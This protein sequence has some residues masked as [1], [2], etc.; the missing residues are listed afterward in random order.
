M[1]YVIENEIIKL[2][3][4]SFGA[5]M[6]SIIKDGVEYLWQGD[7]TYWG[8]RAINLFPYCGRHFQGK[9]TYNGKEYEMKIHGLVKYHECNLVFKDNN[10]LVFSFKDNEETLKFYPFKFELLITYEIEND[11][12]KITYQVINNDEKKMYFAL[13][14]HPGFNIPLNDSLS[15][16]DYYIEFENKCNPKKI[17]YSDNGLIVDGYDDNLLE[18]NQRLELKHNLFDRDIVDYIN[19]DK[20]LTIKT[21]KD[22]R[23]ITVSYPNMR[24]VGFWHK[25]YSDAPY[26]CVEPWTSLPSTEGE[27]EEMI[28]KKDFETLRPNETYTNVITI[29]LN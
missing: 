6:Q 25:P 17:K 11:C 19:A 27:I 24:Y 7:S 26:V 1:E 23:S 4:S 15:F 20:K 21:D 8:E 5:E 18:D 14:A 16:E 9:Y 10:K 3:V 13:G 22:K 12:I 29:N 28:N 2:T